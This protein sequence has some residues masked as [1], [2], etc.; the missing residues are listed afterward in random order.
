MIFG[1]LKIYWGTQKVIRL[2]KEELSWKRRSTRMAYEN[3]LDERLMSAMGSGAKNRRSWKDK[4][5]EKDTEKDTES[6]EEAKD[7]FASDE[8]NGTGTY[9]GPGSRNGHH[10]E[11]GTSSGEGGSDKDSIIMGSSNTMPHRGRSLNRRTM[12]FSGHLYKTNV[13]IRGSITLC[14]DIRAEFDK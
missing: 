12:S 11:E 9:P 4:D 3:G 2:K 14:S 13:S 6:P 1:M 7:V 8:N 10:Q 5:I